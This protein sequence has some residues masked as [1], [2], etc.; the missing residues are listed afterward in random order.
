MRHFAC[1]AGFSAG[2]NTVVGALVLTAGFANTSLVGFP[3]LEALLGPESLKPP[4]IISQIGSFLALSTLGL[5]MAAGFSGQEGNSGGKGMLHRLFGFPPFLALLF[6]LAI[7]LF[8]IDLPESVDSVM[9]DLASSLV[10]VALVAVGAQ[11]RFDLASIASYK[12]PLAV[13]LCFK[14]ILVPLVFILFY[15]VGIHATGKE[16]EITVLESAMAP[17][18][19]GAIIAERFDLDAELAYLLVCVGIPLSLLTV[20]GWFFAVDAYFD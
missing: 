17:M 12:L 4:S 6:S 1:W 15:V 20:P 7:Y 13:G 9:L 5:F 18:I 19:T 8:G 16:I 2:G 14:L 3:V 11:V 10:P